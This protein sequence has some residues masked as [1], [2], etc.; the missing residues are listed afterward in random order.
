[1]AVCGDLQ[2]PKIRVGKIPAETGTAS[3]SGGGTIMLQNGDE[4]ILSSK[5][6]ESHIRKG[7]NGQDEA[8]LS[9]TYKELVNEVEVGHKVLINDGAIR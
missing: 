4:V 1:M 3:R 5:A 2:G 6:N 9:L 7:K 8:V